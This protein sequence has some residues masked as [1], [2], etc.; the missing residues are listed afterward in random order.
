MFWSTIFPFVWKYVYLTE[1]HIA[2]EYCSILQKKHLAY[3]QGIENS[4]V[5]Y[6]S[7]KCRD[8]G[9]VYSVY[10]ILKGVLRW[11]KLACI[12]GN[13]WLFRFKK[14][15]FLSTVIY[16]FLESYIYIYICGRIFN[17]IIYNIYIY[18]HFLTVNLGSWILAPNSGYCYEIWSVLVPYTGRKLNVHKTLRRRLEHTW[19]CSNIHAW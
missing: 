6:I 10:D 15:F 8:W 9:W 12:W 11:C 14:V 16:I 5:N 7:K 13:C 4:R 2:R 17:I 1:P 18:T 19:F 3:T